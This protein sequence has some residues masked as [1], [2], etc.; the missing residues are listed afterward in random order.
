MTFEAPKLATLV[1]DFR[2]L[3]I[4]TLQWGV[5]GTNGGTIIPNDTATAMRGLRLGDP[6]GASNHTISSVNTTAA[7]RFDMWDSEIVWV[8]GSWAPGG[9]MVTTLS[10]TQSGG[11][12]GYRF[13]MLGGN[14]LTVRS[15]EAGTTYTGA[16]F[17]DGSGSP[18]NFGSIRY[19]RIAHSAARGKIEFYGGNSPDGSDQR[20]L[21]SDL[22]TGAKG[23]LSPTQAQIDNVT[24]TMKTSGVLI[25]DSNYIRA[26]NAPAGGLQRN[27][28]DPSAYYIRNFDG[29]TGYVGA[30][31]F[32]LVNNSMSHEYKLMTSYTTTSA[33]D[34]A[35]ISMTDRVMKI[36][37]DGGSAGRTALRTGMSTGI[38]DTNLEVNVTPLTLP[39]SNAYFGIFWRAGRLIGT[40]SDVYSKRYQLTAT[41]AG[42]SLDVFPNSDT[43]TTSWAAPSTSLIQI[44]LPHSL[45]AT[46]NYR[47]NHFNNRIIVFRDG[48]EVINVTDIMDYISVAGHIGF[49]VGNKTAASAQISSVAIHDVRVTTAYD[50]QSFTS[51]IAMQNRGLGAHVMTGRRDTAQ[52]V[53]AANPS[54]VSGM[55]TSLGAALKTVYHYTNKAAGGTNSAPVDTAVI[56]AAKQYAREGRANVISMNCIM[57]QLDQLSPTMSSGFQADLLAWSD[58]LNSIG[59]QVYVDVLPYANLNTP[60][61]PYGWDIQGQVNTSTTTTAS[62]ILG[63]TGSMTTNQYA[64]GTV[65]F[66]DAAN[67]MYTAAIVSNTTTGITF[68][69]NGATPAVGSPIYISTA[70]NRL[71]TAAEYVTAY[72]A[73][74]T[75]MRAV[76]CRASFIF[77]MNWASDMANNSGTASV[78]STGHFAALYPGDA[79]VDAFLIRAI[80]VG[81]QNMGAAYGTKLW[82]PLSKMLAG[83][84]VVSTSYTYPIPV[85]ETPY[86]KMNAQAPTKRMF[87]IA[88]SA[89]THSRYHDLSNGFGGIP[90]DITA[91]NQGTN[92]AFDASLGT[93]LSWNPATVSQ[94]NPSNNIT[95][96]QG[97]RNNVTGPADSYLQWNLP[98]SGVSRISATMYF[99]LDVLSQASSFGLIC[100]IRNGSGGLITLGFDQNINRCLYITAAT[101]AG[102]T[103]FGSSFGSAIAWYRADVTWDDTTGAYTID[104]TQMGD[105]STD[106]PFAAKKSSTSGTATPG[107]ATLVQFGNRQGTL[108]NP[109]INGIE[110]QAPKVSWDTVATTYSKAKWMQ[111]ALTLRGFPQVT[112]MILMSGD[113]VSDVRFTSATLSTLAP[114]YYGLNNVDTRLDSSAYTLDKI[115]SVV[116]LPSPDRVHTAPQVKQLGYESSAAVGNLEYMYL[117]ETSHV[118]IYLVPRVGGILLRDFNLGQASVRGVAEDR[119]NSDGI[120]DYSRWLSSKAVALNFVTFDDPS[121]SA[122]FYAD[123]LSSWASPRR[124]PVLVYKFK[125]GEE[126]K[127]NLRPDTSDAPWIV[128]GIRAGF[129]EVQIGFVGVD[130]KDYSTEINELLLQQSVMTQVTTDGTAATAPKVRVYGG[131]TGCTNPNIVLVSEETKQGGAVARISLGT[132]AS[133][134]FIPANQYLE[135]D[136]N[137]RTV[138]LNGVP[139]EGS[140]YL[141]YLSDRQWFHIEPYYN[142]VLLQTDDANGYG[143]ILYP[144]AYL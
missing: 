33:V 41:L 126:R 85:G 31:R 70:T 68:V 46:Y 40:G 62:N 21:T 18:V 104:V 79:Y 78:A 14:S 9:V 132:T 90:F 72:R 138:Q 6:A 87:L 66:F 100:S 88:G 139:G 75:Y 54:I 47:I 11:L 38:K 74:V 122:A 93:W 141:R 28:Q 19:L 4:D 22:G 60:W 55:E 121:G 124:R 131:S 50:D 49:D 44:A 102:G 61:S 13:E 3:Q 136:M 108:T 34:I 26:V 107:T 110:L 101:G 32:N 8:I 105:D 82:R 67:V 84:G 112:S 77:S 65:K 123:V 95:T 116:G 97:V 17:L 118:P 81:I 63:M 45:G 114:V 52:V 120:R 125:D 16:A 64:G 83:D 99:R 27:P 143:S 91:A 12:Y 39:D 94:F 113:Q 144:D 117:Q 73:I 58:A 92:A 29:W 135:I 129:K 35:D 53:M 23:T 71:K 43:W 10:I 130:G 56:V 98:S 133:T 25:P 115:Q 142:T 57:P 5:T 69:S 15:V 134:V 86:A 140:S 106:Q 20:I 36:T 111:E 42:L 127:I 137:E 59:G 96:Q 48:V 51:G 7:K 24:V 2:N 109:I 80:N 30:N 76:G 37:G 89:E 103:Q 1:D 128:D 119:P